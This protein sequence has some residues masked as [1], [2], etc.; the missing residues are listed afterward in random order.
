MASVPI[1]GLH[2]GGEV[3]LTTAGKLYVDGGKFPRDLLRTVKYSDPRPMRV[4]THLPVPMPE[5]CDVKRQIKKHRDR[6]TDPKER[7]SF[8]PA[9]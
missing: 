6:L 5:E 4:R 8:A 3:G 9:F 2:V 7:K 1:L